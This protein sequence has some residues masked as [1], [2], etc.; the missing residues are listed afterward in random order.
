MRNAALVSGSA[1]GLVIAAAAV[2]PPLIDWSAYGGPLS[3]RLGAALGRPVTIGGPLAVRLLPTPS[4]SAGNVAIG[5]PPGMDGELLRAERLR[6]R[7]DFGALLGGAIKLSAIELDRPELMLNQDG[8]GFGG[9]PLGKSADSAAASPEPSSPEPSSPAT[10]VTAAASSSAHSADDLEVERVLVRDGTLRL[11]DEALLSDLSLDLGLGGRHG[12]F[13][14]DGSARW[15]DTPLT[16]AGAMDRL[17]ADRPAATTLRLGF[18]DGEGTLDGEVTEGSFHGRLALHGMKGVTAAGDMTLSSTEV[19]AGPLALKVG[20]DHGTAALALALDGSPQVDFRLEMDSLDLDAWQKGQTEPPAVT[21]TA[22]ADTPSQP[23]QA[24]ATAAEA[25]RPF[26]LSLPRSLFAAATLSVDRLRW[27]GRDIRQTRLEVVL[28]GGEILVRQART[29]LPGDAE[30]ALEGTFATPAGLPQFDGGLTLSGTDS[31][32][33]L[34]WLGVEGTEPRRF[35][36]RAPLTM[37]WPEI[38]TTD[39]VLNSDRIAARASAALRLGDH[40]AIAAA[41]ALPGLEASLRGGLETGGRITGASFGLEA[42][43]G[44]HPLGAL[45]ITIPPAL[46]RLGPLSVKGNADGPLDALAVETYAEGGGLHLSAKGNLNLLVPAPHA[47]LALSA[48]AA[49]LGHVLGL[50]GGRRGPTGAF[51]LDARLDGDTHAFDLSGL[52]LRAGPTTFTGQS[53]VELGGARPLVVA[54]LNADT[55]ALDLLGTSDRSGQLLPGGPLMPPIVAPHPLSAQPAAARPQNGQVG[56]GASPFSRDPLDLAALNALDS[57]LSLKAGHVTAGDWRLD[58]AT[59]RATLNDGTVTVDSLN[60]SL[61]G[62]RLEAQGVLATGSVPRLRAQVSVAGT[63]LGAA[64]LRAAG[65]TIRQGRLDADMRFATSGRSPYE[66]AAHLDGD[67]R[68]SVKNG[69]LDGF[70][71]PEVNRQMGNL[72]NIGNVLV[73]VQSGLAGGQ[74]PFSALTGS[75]QAKGG[76]IISPDLKLAAEGGGADTETTV[77]LGQWSTDSRVTFHLARAP[78][79]PVT[80]RLEGPMENPRKVIDLNALQRHLV[81]NGLGRALAPQESATEGQPREKNTGKNILKNLLRGLS[82]Q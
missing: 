71:L 33:L 42:P 57:R 69:V 13:Q 76:T 64:R 4:L 60:G 68:L 24:P 53:R 51:A 1:L 21:V 40:P 25:K 44:L 39:L 3:A 29:L 7:L 49:S 77:N 41:V 55:L 30:A 27:H 52:S 46:E 28:D 18:A 73:M 20:D 12:P 9:W 36:L 26:R 17:S 81:A 10:T 65:L 63:E 19:Q 2:L 6:L 37:A 74:T 58:D 66:M 56:F 59:L 5:N 32:S 23:P 48:R 67:G 62:G 72:R 35:A 82:G 75:F 78:Q 34:A 47:T 61:F 79:V 11:G 80:I 15:G 16:I 31:A 54:D 22:A 70:D 14:I 50:M 43:Q 45:G 8:N 38:R